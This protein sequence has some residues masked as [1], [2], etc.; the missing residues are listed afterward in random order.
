MARRH[1]EVQQP[2]QQR[3]PARIYLLDARR[4]S[5]V[6]QRGRT[7]R[8]ADVRT[9]WAAVAL[10]ERLGAPPISSERLR[11]W[12]AMQSLGRLRWGAWLGVRAAGDRSA[13]LYVE[14]PRDARASALA[15]T[16]RPIL[17]SGRLK[18]RL[19]L[20]LERERVLLSPAAD[21]PGR[22][23]RVHGFRG[24]QPA[25]AV[26]AR[27]L[28]GTLRDAQAHRA[29]M[30]KLRLQPKPTPNHIRAYSRC[31]CATGRSGC[32]AH[33]H[34]FSRMASRD[35]THAGRVRRRLRDGFQS[36]SARPRNRYVCCA[37]RCAAR[38]PHR[39]QR[40]GVARFVPA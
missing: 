31:S 30:G 5:A 33:P 29:A 16:H 32:V 15:A 24:S 17:A 11:E 40:D 23:A 9:R 34:A 1:L 12:H 21:V 13:R 39:H 27:S 20:R 35:E 10:A 8:N 37:E 22:A 25:A 6:C 36:R 3:K 7:A 38:G 2:H 19:R 14:A 4:R 18:S 28:C 26:D